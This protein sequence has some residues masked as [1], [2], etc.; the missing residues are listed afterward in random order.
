MTATAQ[1]DDLY[2]AYGS[3]L[4][5][6]RLTVW[7]LDNGFGE[8]A[9]DVLGP[10]Y[11]ADYQLGF[12]RFS[13]SWAGGV[14]DAVEA[15]G[16]VLP[17]LV[18]RVRDAATWAALDAKEGA[19]H[20][21]RQVA[22]A[23]LT[24]DGGWRTVWTYRVCAPVPFVAPGPAYLQVVERGRRAWGLTLDDLHAAAVGT[25]APLRPPLF[26]YGTLRRG[27]PNA[28]LLGE[29]EHRPAVCAGRLWQVQPRPPHRYPA[30]TIEPLHPADQLAGELVHPDPVRWQTLDHLEGFGGFGHEHGHLYRRM[31]WT[32]RPA[33]NL[34]PQLCWI[35]AMPEPP[36]G[37]RIPSG[38]WLAANAS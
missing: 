20:A 13:H 14:A 16:A 25:P 26:V 18:L 24:P 1:P 3:N 38:D 15:Q 4:D 12:T 5:L 23:A 34:P 32:A 31:L 7:C 30:A 2:F 19:P 9:V 37:P 17:G 27:E 28:A 36:A 33:P 21:Y 6:Q 29:V 35:Y 10:A 8:P 11:L 22:G